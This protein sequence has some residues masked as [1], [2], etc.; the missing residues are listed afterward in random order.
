MEKQEALSLLKDFLDRLERS[1]HDA[2]SALVGENEVL[3]I[4]GP[5]GRTT[6]I[7]DDILW[8]H[9]PPNGDIRII[10]SVDDG[11]QRAFTPLADSRLV[12]P[13]SH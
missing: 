9:R 2:L 13:P 1:G 3:E 10:G 11:S 8:D 7:E 12:S 5:S 6:Q 4:T